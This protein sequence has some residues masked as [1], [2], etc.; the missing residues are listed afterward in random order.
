MEKKFS[1]ESTLFFNIICATIFSNFLRSNSV[2][3]GRKIKEPP[4]A[5]LEADLSEVFLK[6]LVVCVKVCIDFKK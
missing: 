4:A 2:D 1:D 6:I 3:N 5:L